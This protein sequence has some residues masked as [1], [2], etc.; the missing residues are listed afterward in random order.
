MTPVYTILSLFDYTGNW[1]KPYRDNGYKV[2][3]IDIKLGT[4]ILTFNYQAIPEVYGILCAVPCTDFAVSGARWFA[5]KDRDGRTQ[6]SIELVK[7]SL[8]IINYFNPHFWALENPVGRIHKLI[9]QLGKPLL[10]FNPCDYGDAYTK[11]TCLWGKFNIP[12]ENP[13]QP[14]YHYSA[15]KKSSHLWKKLGGKS[16]KTKELRSQT[17][18]GFARAFYEANK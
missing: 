2:I 9:P 8:E 14:V 5:E 3:Q 17:P 18:M 10:I 1:S 12:I 4:D 6:K 15:G 11:K 13:V 7:K 16:E